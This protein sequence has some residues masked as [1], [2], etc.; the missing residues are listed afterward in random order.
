MEHTKHIWRAV[1]IILCLPVGYI[2]ARHFLLPKSFGQAGHYRYD[3]LADIAAKEP[4]H[5]DPDPA[6]ACGKCHEKQV[7]EKGADKH[8]SVSC[9]VCHGPLARH[10]QGDK[11]IADMPKNPNYKLCAVCH[12]K[13]E[14][15]PK[16]FPQVDLARHVGTAAISERACFECHSAHQPSPLRGERKE[17]KSCH[18]DQVAALTEG[19]HAKLSCEVCHGPRAK[20]VNPEG[21]KIAE[22]PKEYRYS[23]CVRCHERPTSGGSIPQIEIRA[24]LEKVRRPVGQEIPKDVCKECHQ[25]PHGPVIPKPK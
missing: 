10:A 22:M 13:L 1:L 17:C 21:D 6:K 14:S 3:A 15:R 11:K 24:H 8:K 16:E 2:L 7:A 18:G 4:V 5:G 12:E 20:H 19:K 25:H 9:E 23:L